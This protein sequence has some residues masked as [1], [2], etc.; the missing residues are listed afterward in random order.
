[1][2]YLKTKKQ[3]NKKKEVLLG[4]CD[5]CRDEFHSQFKVIDLSCYQYA[6]TALIMSAV[7]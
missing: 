3:T 1:M 7:T 6:M 5:P 4:V 2:I